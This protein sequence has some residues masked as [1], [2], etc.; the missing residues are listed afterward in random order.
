MVGLR[1]KMRVLAILDSTATSW[2]GVV[3]ALERVEAVTR[4]RRCSEAYVTASA[5]Q[6]ILAVGGYSSGGQAAGELDIA[7]AAEVLDPLQ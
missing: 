6:C 7:V 1:E 3:Q 2:P 5:L 4:V